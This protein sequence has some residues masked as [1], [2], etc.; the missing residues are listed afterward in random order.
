MTNGE[1]IS[2]A[3]GDVVSITKDETIFLHGSIGAHMYVVLDGQ[4][5][6]RIGDR[7]V[8]VVS[9]GQFFGE[10]ALVDERPRA[11]TAIARTKGSLLRIDSKQF[12]KLVRESPDF[13]LKLLRVVVGRVR[14]ADSLGGLTVPTKSSSE[15]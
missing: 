11:G 2:H 12:L 4:V 5:E 8:D 13:A 10:M 14:R 3:G 7:V 9:P 6:I 15:A 1:M